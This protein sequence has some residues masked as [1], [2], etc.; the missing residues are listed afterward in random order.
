[1]RT[2]GSGDFRLAWITDCVRGKDDAHLNPLK[3]ATRVDLNHEIRIL[4]E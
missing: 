2:L 4:Q 1:L 3:F